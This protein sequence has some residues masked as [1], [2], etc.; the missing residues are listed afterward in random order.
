[1]AHLLLVTLIL[2]SQPNVLSKYG[3]APPSIGDPYMREVVESYEIQIPEKKVVWERCIE[4][5]GLFGRRCRVVY[6]KR[7]TQTMSSET[8]LRTVQVAELALQGQSGAK[9]TAP[10]EIELEAPKT[11]G[12]IALLLANALNEIFPD[13]TSPFSQMIRTIND[14]AV[15]FRSDVPLPNSGQS[16]GSV[17]LQVRIDI[18]RLNRR[19]IKLVVVARDKL[20]GNNSATEAQNRADEIEPLMTAQ[21]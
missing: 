10:I 12:A 4:R 13:Q 1:M 7:M 9:E 16:T 2:T 21:P 8:R 15:D 3:E 17:D 20:N 11:A 19:K 5:Y 14:N 6:R 18:D